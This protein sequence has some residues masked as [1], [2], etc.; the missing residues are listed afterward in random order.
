[1]AVFGT[2]DRAVAVTKSDTTVYDCKAIFVGGAGN[3]AVQTR[4]TTGIADGSPDAAVTLTGC[5][6]GTIY[7]IAAY[8]IMSTNTTATAIVALY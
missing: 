1:M 3:V 8:R 5:L 7:P 2:Y 6:A 4:G